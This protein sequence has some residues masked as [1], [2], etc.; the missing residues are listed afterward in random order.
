V[1]DVRDRLGWDPPKDPS[2]QPNKEKAAKLGYKWTPAGLSKQKVN[3]GI[4]EEE[5]STLTTKAYVILINHAC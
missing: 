1:S 4:N 2:L 3:A 5:T